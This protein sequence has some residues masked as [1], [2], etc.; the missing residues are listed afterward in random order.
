LPPIRLYKQKNIIRLYKRSKNLSSDKLNKS[1]YDLNKELR[2]SSF[3]NDEININNKKE[4]SRAVK[5][6]YEKKKQSGYSFIIN[7]N[8]NR[9]YKAGRSNSLK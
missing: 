4:I 1:N 9:Y 7:K 8:N 6:F 3:I 5:N 2:N